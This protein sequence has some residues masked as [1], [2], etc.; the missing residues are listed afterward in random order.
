MKKNVI[1]LL[2]AIVLAPGSVGSVPAWAAETTVQDEVII[3]EEPTEVDEGIDTNVSD[4]SDA[5]K[6]EDIQSVDD[7]EE[8]PENEVAE[9]AEEMGTTEDTEVVEAEEEDV[10]SVIGDTSAEM[11]VV[12]EPQDEIEEETTETTETK[13]SDAT[14]VNA[15]DAID[16]GTCGENATWTGR[17]IKLPYGTGSAGRS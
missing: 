6:T 2:L 5:G 11:A 1:A 12:E 15:G 14:I 9:S 7:M 17:Q 8:E 16:S 13:E 10:E 3:E 4:V